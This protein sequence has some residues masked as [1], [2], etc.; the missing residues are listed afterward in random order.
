MASAS[1]KGG[2]AAG[3]CV[4]SFFW[5]VLWNCWLGGI[6]GPFGD[7]ECGLKAKTPV[8][9]RGRTESLIRIGA[10]DARIFRSYLIVSDWG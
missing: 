8:S 4:N 3:A 10:D 6:P 7:E 1:D 9:G 5:K 2:L